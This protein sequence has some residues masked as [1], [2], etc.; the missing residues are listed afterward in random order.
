MNLTV[1]P[2]RSRGG[3]GRV[4]ADCFKDFSLVIMLCQ[5]VLSQHC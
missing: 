1:C 4:L 3:G 5:P 2:P